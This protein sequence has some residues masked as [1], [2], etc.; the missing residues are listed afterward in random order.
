MADFHPA[1]QNISFRVPQDVAKFSGDGAPSPDD[2]INE[3]ENW[4]YILS[5]P[6]LIRPRMSALFMTGA[7][8]EWYNLD[9][10]SLPPAEQTWELFQQ[11]LRARFARGDESVIAR[12]AQL[13]FRIVRTNPPNFIHSV[14]EFNAAFSRNQVQCANNT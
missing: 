10:M 3:L 5:T 8:K 7:A 2:F 4:Y 9:F 6:P 12:R 13:T 1:A 14:N 11:K